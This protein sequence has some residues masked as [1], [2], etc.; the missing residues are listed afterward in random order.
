MT[1]TLEHYNRTA[2]RYTEINHA[3]PTARQQ[4][5]QFMAHFRAQGNDGVGRPLRLLDAGSG[6]GRDTLMFLEEGFEVDAFDGS[7]AMAEISTR[8]TGRPTRVMRFE[9]L[10]LPEDHYDAV[11]AMASMLH[12][13]R[14]K[15][16]Q[17]FVELGRSLVPGGLLYASFKL[18]NSTR[19]VPE[20][21]RVFT[22]LD[23]EGVAALLEATEGFELVATTQREAPA[24]QSYAAPWFSVTLKRPGPAP[25]LKATTP[26]L[27]R[28]GGPR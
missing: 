1:K 22:D 3:L 24:M 17:T 6:T 25:S 13:E 10:D 28:P 15:L 8:L 9:E 20:D 2:D 16:A 12:V 5:D 26:S 11:W 14:E 27:K 18:G 21:G 19:E 23:N 4:V 7:E